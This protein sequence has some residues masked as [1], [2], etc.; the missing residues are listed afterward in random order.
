M[1]SRIKVPCNSKLSLKIVPGLPH[2]E[3]IA[4]SE[5]PISSCRD[6]GWVTVGLKNLLN[7]KLNEAAVL[8]EASR[9]RGAKGTTNSCRAQLHH[10]VSGVSNLEFNL[11]SIP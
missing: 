2:K 1:V 6:W 9:G 3:E 7:Q 10:A 5:F 8:R 4:K 11:L